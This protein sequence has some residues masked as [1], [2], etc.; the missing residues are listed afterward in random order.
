MNEH[1][2]NQQDFIEA[3]QQLERAP[4]RKDILLKLLEGQSD[5]TIAKSLK[6]HEG[7]VRKHISDLCVLFGLKKLS[8]HSKRAEL[9]T[10]IAKYKPGLITNY[11]NVDQNQSEFPRKDNVLFSNTD[12]YGRMEEQEQLEKWL[13]NCHVITILG[14]GGI[15]KSSLSKKLWINSKYKFEVM[16]WYNF[17][18][19]PRPNDILKNI[20]TSLQPDLSTS[21]SLNTDELISEIISLLKK[22]R[23]LIVFDNFESILEAGGKSIYKESFQKYGDFIKAVVR[24]DHQSSLIINTREKPVHL[25]E[26][27]GNNLVEFLKLEGL[28]PKDSLKIIES[29]NL[30]GTD[31]DKQE[32][33]K[34]CAG[35]PLI[36]KIECAFIREI[37]GGNI[38]NFINHIIVNGT[39]IGS[40]SVGI[41]NLLEQQFE[42]LSRR[43]I[44]IMYWLA[45]NRIP[46]SI[47][48]LHNQIVQK[49]TL[50]EIAQNIESLKWR[51]LI[52]IN[53]GKFTIQDVIRGFAINR[54][55][56]RLVLEIKQ[57]TLD[58]FN[59][60]PLIQAKSDEYIREIQAQLILEPVVDSIA[61]AE[62]IFLDLLKN[63]KNNPELEK[64]FRL[65]GYAAGNIVNILIHIKDELSNIDCSFLTIWQAYLEGK[66][67]NDINFEGSDLSNSVFTKTFGT[68]LS[69]AFSPQENK[70]ATGDT[71]NEIRFWQGDDR[72]I[73]TGRGHSNWIR[74]VSFS[75]DGTKL[76]S[77][78]DDKTV[79][80][81]DTKTGECLKTFKEEGHTERVWT[82]AFNHD[83]TKLASGSEDKTIK[84]WSVEIGQCL[85]TLTE[86]ENWIYSVAFNH[87]GTKLASGSEDKTIKI[88]NVE[89]GQCLCTLAEHENRVRSVAF[90]HDGTK[91]ASGSEDKTI[92]IWNVETGQ[93]LRTLAEHEN[94][95]R[96]VAFNHDGTKLASG[97]EDKTIKIWNVET[98]Q[99][100]RTL[101]GH[102]NRIWSIAFSPNP[103]NCILLS[104]SDDKTLRRWDT[105][106]GQCLQT[107]QG[108]T[109][110]DWSI[111]F[112]PDGTT[113][114]SS[115]DNAI[116][117]LWK[118]ESPKDPEDPENPQILKLKDPDPKNPKILKGHN[119]RIRKVVFSQDGR[120]LASGSDDQTIKV[121][122][123]ETGQCIHTLQK[124]QDRVL[125][126]AFHPDSQ[127]LASGGDDRI[128][129]LWNISTGECLNTLE[130]HKSWIWS[131]AFSPDG[132]KLASGSEDQTVKLWDISTV[133]CLDT[134]EG[135][136]NWVRSVAFSSDGKILASGS[137]DQTVKLW[138]TKTGECLGTLKDEVNTNWVR[139]I[140]F[141]PN[142]ELLA[143]AGE[144]KT[145]NIWN[146]KT[147]SLFKKLSD[148]TDRIWSIAFKPVYNKESIDNGT[149]ASSGE[150]G[151]IRIWDI[152]TKT[153]IELKYPRIYEGMKITGVKGLTTSEINN[154]IT[155]G[156]VN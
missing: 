43:Q 89:T 140:S 103:N 96:S 45:I 94:R 155:L 20:L 148:H 95:V 28:S 130:G 39:T 4:R 85:R 2:I 24:E 7:S 127:I 77:A 42:K 133:K 18:N 11:S 139:S 154:L 13:N 119:N 153:N 144:G 46:M 54:L 5:S 104:S 32:I 16:K 17:E 101:K 98:A 152:K 92:K 21:D 99:C 72:E 105:N 134:L 49:P 31:D 150:D 123:V 36:I 66:K 126:V 63:R 35:I 141:H 128:I 88:W 68:V 29:N 65:P 108:Y 50:T 76:A 109:N 71:K 15:G 80:I 111:A 59:T 40:L 136:Q 33:I 38:H 142:G 81:W 124:H 117:K 55:I 145:V 121:W 86:H 122:E 135:H 19:F 93:C 57:E 41:E 34:I 22:E 3:F 23:C 84:I 25:A 113:L 146:I 70:W 102:T 100:L 9:V 60:I 137:E 107:L 90:N 44:E 30:D 74:Q 82:V 6:I 83:G 53:E 12:F 87:D 143:S 14:Q 132:T 110:W 131:I 48:D 125:T 61:N 67:L 78:S 73:L 69:I 26:F 138:D 62:S 52:E 115:A 118:I 112:S 79:K 97:S 120:L 156:A 149:L 147:Q 91:L 58:L 75:R 27:E 129:R 116:I 56:K 114:A 8:G 51:S 10:L 37:F 47:N 106:A 64:Q 1:I 151:I